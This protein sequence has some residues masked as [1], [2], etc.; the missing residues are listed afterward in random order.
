ML[1]IFKVF[2]TPTIRTSE[3]DVFSPQN[4]FFTQA[5]SSK[6]LGMQ[7]ENLM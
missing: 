5:F 1:L 3:I 7:K 2:E 4:D 6:L